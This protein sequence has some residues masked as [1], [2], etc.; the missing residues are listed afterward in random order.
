MRSFHPAGGG[1]GAVA[2]FF[3]VSILLGSLGLINTG[4][5][6]GG[7]AAQDEPV[8]SGDVIVILADSNAPAAEVEAAANAEGVEP[9]V[10]FTNVVD[11]YAAN[12]TPAQA[13]QLAES[14]AVAAIFPN[15]PVY[16]AAQTVPAGI[17]RIGATANEIANINGVDQR[18]NVDVAVLDSG[19]DP[20]TGDLNVA[21]G[22]DCSSS[23]TFQ[24]GSGHGT[25]V[26]GTIA[27]LD[28]NIG[29]V[30]VAP[31]A[32]LWSVRV[33]SD[34]GIGNDATLIC[35]LDWVYAN[36]STIDV[37]NMSV[38][39]SGPDAPCTRSSNE[40]NWD[41]PLHES[42]CKVY[43]AGI[44]IVAAAGNQNRDA[45]TTTPATF[46]EVIAVSAFADYDGTS[47]GLGT[48]CTNPDD[49]FF[50]QTDSLGSNWGADIDIMAPGVCVLS[51]AMGGGAGVRT[52]TSMAAP[53][54]TGALALYLSQNPNASPAQ[55]KSWLLGVAASQDSAD[56]ILGGDTDGI[57]EPVLR[58]GPNSI[59]TPTPT[60]T[61]PAP[62]G[63]L[64]IVNSDNSAN[65]VAHRDNNV[66][67]VWMTKSTSVAPTS[68]WVLVR[69]QNSV[70]VGAIRWV[71]GATGMADSFSIETSNDLVTWKK[72][73]TK[74][75]KPVGVWQEAATRSGTTAKYVRFTFTNPNGDLK[76]GGI[77][78]IQLWPPGAAPL[79]PTPTPTATPAPVKYVIAS[80]SQTL[81]SQNSNSV[82][83]GNG[84]T[85]WRS[86]TSVTPPATA[87]V[88]I[89]LGTSKKVGNVRWMFGLEGA[90]DQITI[91]VS[92][93][94]VDW[95][96]IGT[97]SNGSLYEWQQLSTNLNAKFVRWTFTNPNGDAIIGGLSEVEVW[98][99]PGGAL[100]SVT[101]PATATPT[102]TPTR[103]PTVTP[104]ATFTATF[105]ATATPTP[106]ETPTETPTATP[107][108]T[109]TDTPTETPA[110]TATPE[111][112][113]TETPV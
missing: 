44:P 97:R 107:T 12:V 73:T 18:V 34:F 16:Q 100:T 42:I 96:T 20:T 54:V 39:G 70:P 2:F 43:D 69:L 65:G 89:S 53:H 47:G 110:D 90:A 67:T 88:Q 56:G 61:V 87:A 108:E 63:A 80:T 52:G 7:V 23:G 74:S 38:S 17:K 78:E 95:T 81:N 75:N 26:S 86:K 113:A 93:D 37:V 11:G 106:T 13:E 3:I 45:E 64:T 109:A 57:A 105:S 101:L 84:G 60:P 50:D 51:T 30:G 24:D 36:R 62:A 1:R 31:G 25:H 111:P 92:T 79:N 4:P 40:A 58:V 83:D 46:D 6:P 104:A 49:H 29:V 5:G 76:L 28:N 22:I 48:G 32:R 19:I 99:G 10:V 82:K 68:A 103:T 9:T 33:L 27:A 35:G 102:A 77:A 8:P 66:N 72:V 112:T 91:A 71:F 15:N 85:Y 59:S 55:A 98:S 21:G 94:G 41:S 14:P